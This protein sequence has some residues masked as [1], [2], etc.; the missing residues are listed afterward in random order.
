[1]TWSQAEHN[2]LMEMVRR[3]ASRS[4]MKSVLGKSPSMIARRIKKIQAALLPLGHNN[5]MRKWMSFCKDKGI[6]FL[7]FGPWYYEEGV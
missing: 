1:M 4:E 2:T 6:K 5:F 3:N 7:E